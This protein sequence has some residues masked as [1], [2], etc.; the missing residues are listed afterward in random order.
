MSLPPFGERFRASFRLLA[1]LMPLLFAF[2]VYRLAIQL[3]KQVALGRYL[4]WLE[5]VELTL[6]LGAVVLA[7]L[8]SVRP[9]PGAVARAGRLALFVAVVANM[10]L[11]GL[12]VYLNDPARTPVPWRAGLAALAVGLAVVYGRKPIDEQ[13]LTLRTLARVGA[14]GLALLALALPYVL[15]Q[16]VADT[17]R[18]PHAL[19]PPASMAPKPHAP[20][21]I[22]LVTFDELR[23]SSTSLSDPSRDTTPALAALAAE[24][25][26]FT[27]MH[28]AGDQTII[29]MPTV[30]TGM[31]PP[32]IFSRVRNGMGYIR[33]GSIS[34]VAG[35]LRAA[36]YRTAYS[37]LLVSPQSFG[38]RDEYDDGW[39][40]GT[41]VDNPFNSASFVP[42][43]ETFDLLL[44]NRFKRH[45]QRVSHL[46]FDLHPVYS[47]IEQGL[48]I[49]DEPV[50]REFLWVHLGLPHH[51]YYRIPR[52]DLGKL[53][54][55]MQYRRVH[56]FLN[57]HLDDPGF[58]LSA[59]E[60][61][62]RFSDA[63][64][65]RLLD[66]L[67]ASPR[68]SDTL[69][70]VTSDHGTRLDPSKRG[71]YGVG[72]TPEEITHVPLLI[73]APGQ[74]T[75]RRIATAVGHEDVVPTILSQVYPTVPAD[76][77]GTPLLGPLPADHTAYT[78]AMPP[79]YPTPPTA[80]RSVVA[81]RGPLRLTLDFPGSNERLT[82]W[83]TDP[84][85]T[86]DLR[87]SHPKEAAELRSCLE[88]A[89]QPR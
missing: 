32:D 43:R 53:I 58:Y 67:R 33:Q 16:A 56:P 70:I 29:S 41:F 79:S 59:Y 19:T 12:A 72:E 11:V 77:K 14:V 66:G 23:R 9:L 89:L 83:Q 30:L 75:S 25:T 39:S 7:A 49:Y 13:T 1:G 6:V 8:V 76:F 78:W 47:V 57:G 50:D 64:L 18:N 35:Y 36:G 81:Y 38:L 21:R 68:W 48:A 84:Q 63:M 45:F 26:R 37:T 3:Q 42:V 60:D 86:H 82:N 54:K 88:R 24:S 20:T 31:R 4:G 74:R 17:P 34:G 71:V 87:A 27:N 5:F 51:P 15:L 40:V 10:V 2:P 80:T 73:H 62:V 69:L 61:Y 52:S 22:V 44:P 85:G 55:P 28:S 65:G 46:P